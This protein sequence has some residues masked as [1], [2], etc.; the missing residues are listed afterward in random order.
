MLQ[1]QTVD[2]R[3][4]VFVDTFV[5]VHQTLHKAEFS[6]KDVCYKCVYCFAN[7]SG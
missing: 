2:L 7:S 1:Y 6:H 5:E 4:F 3:S